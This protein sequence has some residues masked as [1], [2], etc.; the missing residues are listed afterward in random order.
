MNDIVDDSYQW[1]EP[2]DS[3]APDLKPYADLAKA[4]AEKDQEIA[5]LTMRVDALRRWLCQ[6]VTKSEQYQQLMEKAIRF[7]QLAGVRSAC[8]DAYD[9]LQSPEVQAWRKERKR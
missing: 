6:K 9:F 3:K 5:Y 2:R 8:P 1:S 4:L 7:A